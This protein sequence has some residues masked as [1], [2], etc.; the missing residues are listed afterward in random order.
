MKWSPP[1]RSLVPARSAC[2]LLDS[3]DV[4]KAVEFKGSPNSDIHLLEREIVLSHSGQVI[5]DS[6][7]NT[8][9]VPSSLPACQNWAGNFD[10]Q[11]SFIPQEKIT[12]GVLWTYSDIKDKLYVGKDAPCPVN[13]SVNTVMSDDVSIRV[14]ALYSSPENACEIVRRCVNHSMDEVR[15]GVFEAEHLVRCESSMATYEIDGATGRHSVKVPFENPPVGQKFSTYIYKFACFGS[16]AG[17]P[18][19]RPLMLIFTLEKGGEVIGR[20]KLDVKICACPTR[21]RKTEEQQS[22]VSGGA[23]SAKR[24]DPPEFENLIDS[25]SFA[26]SV[27]FPP[28]PKK[29]RASP[30]E[31]GFYTIAVDNYECFEF[32]KQMKKFYEICS[33]M[34]NLPPEL[35]QRLMHHGS[36]LNV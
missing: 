23:I 9:H 18:N 17:G 3:D 29:S 36:L 26:K 14:M 25:L 7:S 10:F 13:F 19:R 27:T 11:V 30:N 2:I 28:P 1:K 22:I 16:C 32:L 12:K 21:D 8:H 35:K 15:R 4:S 24:K 6:S 5:Q 31:N 20:R 34:G 33:I